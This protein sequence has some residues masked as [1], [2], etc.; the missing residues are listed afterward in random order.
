MAGSL[1]YY[2]IHL[3]KFKFNSMLFGISH[4]IN[5]VNLFNKMCARFH[6]RHITLHTYL[7][8]TIHMKRGSAAVHRCAAYILIT[9]ETR[10]T[11]LTTHTNGKW[12]LVVGRQ[13]HLI[14]INWMRVPMFHRIRSNVVLWRRWWCWWWCTSYTFT[15][16]RTEDFATE[17]RL[18]NVDVA[19]IN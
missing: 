3:H 2:G 8:H 5:Y 19:H 10:Q 18:D 17:T 15:Y 12:A 6:A 1:L 13:I 9:D 16:V 7:G 11:Q 14:I 4:A